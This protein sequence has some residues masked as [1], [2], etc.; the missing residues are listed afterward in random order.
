MGL[1]FKVI[2]VN[3]MDD[4]QKKEYI[5][6]NIPLS[7]G[8]RITEMLK[9]YWLKNPPPQKKEKSIIEKAEEMFT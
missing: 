1:C 2:L 6:K 3:A 8:K 5:I 9:R 4:K 7:S